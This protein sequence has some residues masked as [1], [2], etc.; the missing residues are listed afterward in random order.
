[1]RATFVR[2]WVEIFILVMLVGYAPARSEGYSPNLR[3]EVLRRELYIAGERPELASCLAAASDEISRDP[4][5][6]LIRFEGDVPQVAHMTE[7][8]SGGKLLRLVQFDGRAR[9]REGHWFIDSYKTVEV[10]CD[11]RDEAPPTVRI[12]PKPG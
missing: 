9:I 1:M 11:Q 5:F 3:A 6:D 2:E 12:E 10:F 7:S 8:E 4:R